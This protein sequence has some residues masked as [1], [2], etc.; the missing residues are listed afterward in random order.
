MVSWR[1]WLTRLPFTQEIAGSYP[2]GTT[3]NFINNLNTNIMN[4]FYWITRLDSIDAL[5]TVFAVLCAIV[6]CICLIGFGASL[7]EDLDDDDL[8][9]RNY[10][11]KIGIISL[12]LLF[13]FSTINT[14]IP[15]TKDAYIIYGIGGTFDYLKQNDTAKNLPDKV[16]VAV[17]SYLDKQISELQSASELTDTIKQ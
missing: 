1:N 8:K 9:I 11:K 6:L 3:I 13:A 5:L 12:V 10:F 2:A 4:E 15:S 14:F 16:L 7:D 17:D